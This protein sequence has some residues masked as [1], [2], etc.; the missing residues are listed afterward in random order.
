M[1]IIDIATL[2]NPQLTALS[3]LQQHYQWGARN[4]K[5]FSRFHKLESACLF[6]DLA[7]SRMLSECLAR[8][9]ARHPEK[10]QQITHVAYAHSLHSTYPF[11]ADVLRTVVAEHLPASVEVLSVTQNSCASSFAGLALLQRILPAADASAGFA[12]LLTGDKCFHQT[13]Q[14][15]DQNGVF[16]EGCSAVLVS[17]AADAGG[18]VIEGMG[19]AMIGGLGSRTVITDRQVE[20]RYDHDFMPTMMSAIERAMAT[21]RISAPMIETVL[22]YHMSP[23]TFDRIADRL[24]LERNCVM[25]DNLYR[26][27]HCF[28]G[29]AFINLHDVMHNPAAVKPQGRMLAVAAGVAGTFSAMV[30]RRQEAA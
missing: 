19:W 17:R 1:N 25:R 22:P 28:C 6:P 18:S 14:Y 24:G 7:L 2:I 12:V 15:V 8:L 29:D 10:R 27:G 30:L 26:L 9:L 21:A 3:T 4:Q 16:G 20:N 5:I 13:V 23:S 11:D